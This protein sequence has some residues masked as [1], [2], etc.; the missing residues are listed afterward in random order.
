MVIGEMGNRYIYTQEELKSR[1]RDVKIEVL[2]GFNFEFSEKS[3]KKFKGTLKFINNKFPNDIISG[4]LALNLLG[5]LERDPN[6]IDILIKDKDRF[7]SY[8]KSG[9]GDDD[10]ISPNRLGFRDISYKDG[11]FSRTKNVVVDIFEDIN[12]SFIEMDYNSIKLKIQNPLEIISTKISI[13]NNLSKN[14]NS[15][16]TGTKHGEDLYYIFNNIKEQKF[17]K[18]LKSI[19]GSKI[20]DNIL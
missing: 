15:F 20:F 1:L 13:Y 16:M 19:K 6:D 2:N 12:S 14:G 4:S 18:Y 5:L 9:Y 7:P 11:F 17:L 8:L 3:I 10:D